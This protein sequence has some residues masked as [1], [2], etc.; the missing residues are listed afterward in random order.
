M[1]TDQD[2]NEGD[3][4]TPDKAS[5]V[6][7]MLEKCSEQSGWFPRGPWEAA[8]QQASQTLC[9]LLP[10]P[11]SGTQKADSEAGVKTG[12]GSARGKAGSGTG[13]QR[14]GSLP[15]NTAKSASKH[16]DTEGCGTEQGAHNLLASNPVASTS[17]EAL[18][19]E[20]PA[21]PDPEATM[22]KWREVFSSINRKLQVRC[23]LL[24]F[25]VRERIPGTCFQ[26]FDCSCLVN[27]IHCNK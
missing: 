3:K 12:T 1:E 21:Y 11:S 13:H 10:K 14:L 8:A 26:H 5:K 20:P 18:A 19:A 6:Q 15:P 25:R 16:S 24:C 27:L 22:I 2:A 4:S 17:A 23:C 9:D 7:R